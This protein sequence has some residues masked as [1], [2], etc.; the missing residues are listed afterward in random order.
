MG[1]ISVTIILA[2]YTGSYLGPLPLTINGSTMN[3]AGFT[4]FLTAKLRT[5]QPARVFLLNPTVD[6]L[7]GDEHIRALKNGEVLVAVGDGHRLSTE[8]AKDIEA[9][10]KQQKDLQNELGGSTGSTGRAAATGPEMKEIHHEQSVLPNKNTKTT[11]GGGGSKPNSNQSS[12]VRTPSI[13]KGPAT[14][15]IF[16]N[17]FDLPPNKFHEYILERG[18]QYMNEPEGV[19]K[20]TLPHITLFFP[21]DAE[22]VRYILGTHTSEFTKG[23]AYKE[24]KPLGGDGLFTTLNDNI[25]KTTLDIVGRAGMSYDFRF[26]ENPDAKQTRALFNGIV[27][28]LKEI[29]ERIQLPV[30]RYLPRPANFRFNRELAAVDSLIYRVIAERQKKEQQKGADGGDGGAVTDLL[31]VFWN[32]EFEGMTTEKQRAK[33]LRDEVVTLMIAGHETTANLLNW[34]LYELTKHPDVLRRAREEI[35]TVLGDHADDRYDP[36]WEEIVKCKYL[37]QIVSETLRYHPPVPMV[38]RR[39]VTDVVF[40]EIKYPKGSAFV[41]APY[42]MHRHPKYWPKNPNEWDPD[43]FEFEKEKSEARHPFCYMPFLHGPRNCVGMEFAL[44]EAKTILVMILLK[45]DFE[46][47]PNGP[48]IDGHSALTLHLVPGL[49]LKLTRRPRTGEPIQPTTTTQT[50]TLSSISRPTTSRTFVD[51]GTDSP[52]PLTIIYGSQAGL[53]ESYAKELAAEARLYGFNASVFDIQDYPFQTQLFKQPNVVVVTAT[54]NG[55]P[56]ESARAFYEWLMVM[57]KDA[58]GA[59]KAAANVKFAVFGCGNSRWVRTFQKVP[60]E[61][62]DVL[63]KLG[64]TEVTPMGK[65][66]ANLYI[67][68]DWAKWKDQFWKDVTKAVGLNLLVQNSGNKAADELNEPP[69]TPPFK[70]F[71]ATHT[72]GTSWAIDA[73]YQ[74]RMDTYYRSQPLAISGS[75]IIHAKV[76]K[77]EELQTKDSPRSTRHIEIEVGLGADKKPL[78]NVGDHL[79][80]YPRNP[81]HLVAKLASLLQLDPSTLFI[82]QPSSEGKLPIEPF[83]TPCTLQH[84]LESYTDITGALSPST[85]KILVRILKA[86]K[87]DATE[88]IAALE[89]IA[90]DE[91]AYAAWK[92]AQD[93]T[94]VHVLEKFPS[95][96]AALMKSPTDA[97][98]GGP[99]TAASWLFDLLPR[100][101]PRMYSI[102]SSPLQHASAVHVT[103]AVNERFHPTTKEKITGLSSTW[104]S[105]LAP[106]S[107]I[108]VFINAST[109]RPPAKLETPVIMVGPG[110]GLAPF[111]GFLQHKEEQTKTFNLSLLGPW[112]LY[113][114]CRNSSEDYLY[115]SELE[116]YSS[117]LKLTDLRVA[118]SRQDPNTK[119]YVQHLLK[120]DK[121]RIWEL[122]DKQ[123]AYFYVCGDGSVMAKDVEKAILEVI[124]EEGGRGVEEAEAYY[125]AMDM[126]K[127]VLMD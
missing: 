52:K 92:K 36:K 62:V 90:T 2:N 46:L 118:F 119:V 101:Q 8:K 38:V 95:L 68:D 47:D 57:G 21:Y 12:P 54:Y 22:I 93:N 127:R 32:L 39:S 124:Q 53:C 86:A 103:V 20:F 85:L 111:R 26:C 72:V 27:F 34:T 25:W 89:K 28:I 125:K 4:Q 73:D 82:L 41:I 5:P 19:F 17:L 7:L 37:G 15:P 59:G 6:E 60:S 88:D 94:I 51:L 84:A 77:N 120:E 80:V 75:K 97:S 104:L 112:L 11:N 35:R 106:G 50:A 24:L 16:G 18:L 23:E 43:R 122:I 123:G 99:L 33:Q 81:A 74:A 69:P 1:S 105:K 83:P 114:G 110:T 42:L 56:T 109:F 116:R 13:V 96:C 30:L 102:S 49:T 115:H 71:T 113:F 66:D 70:V 29:D 107:V 58:A 3:H 31:D 79:G 44:L 40:N 48:Q 98:T 64:G 67:D 87:S 78:Y 9:W 61:I 63:K 121:K 100:L 91:V 14:K 117:D 10:W 45:Y 126:E 76:L 65:G 55:E 108:S